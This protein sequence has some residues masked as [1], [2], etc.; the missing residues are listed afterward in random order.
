M[1]RFV[2]GPNDSVLL[3]KTTGEVVEFQCDFEE[4]HGQPRYSARSCVSI[5]FAEHGKV[6]PKCK[7]MFIGKGTRYIEAEEG[8]RGFIYTPWRPEK[9][10][11]PAHWATPKISLRGDARFVICFPT[12]MRH[13]GIILNADNMNLIDEAAH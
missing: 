2:W 7:V 5:N 3:E 8:P 6:Y 11:V 12:G 1:A 9:D 13:Y 10:G 4:F